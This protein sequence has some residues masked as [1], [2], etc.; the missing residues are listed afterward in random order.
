MKFRGVSDSSGE[1]GWGTWNRARKSSE[2]GSLSL[3]CSKAVTA[4]KQRRRWV[5]EM[6]RR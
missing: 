2:E 6:V 1:H 3:S 4:G 5:Q